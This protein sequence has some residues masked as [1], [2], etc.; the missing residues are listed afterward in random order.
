MKIG[1][2]RTSTLKQD[3][4][5]EAQ[6][7]D[8]K[9]AGCEQLFTEQL[10]SVDAE[11]AQLEEAIKFAREGDTLVVTKIDRLARSIKNLVEIEAR[12]SAKG[13]GLCILN[14]AMDTSAVNGSLAVPISMKLSV[15][16]D[17]GRKRLE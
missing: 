10:S 4:G 5:L 13:V 2:G 6:T 7:R 11:R 15:G 14:P 16:Q 9:A 17:S 8:L 3:A 1:Y 12:L